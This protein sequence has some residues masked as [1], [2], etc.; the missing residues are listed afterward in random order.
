MP[1]NI[2]AQRSKR[3]RRFLRFR[4]LSL[5]GFLTVVA[6]G[7]GLWRSWESTY[8][9]RELEQ[10][11]RASELFSEIEES[12]LVNLVW[13]EQADKLLQRLLPGDKDSAFARCVFAEELF[14]KTNYIDSQGEPRQVFVF[15]NPWHFSMVSTIVATDDQFRL[16]GWKEIRPGHPESVN[17]TTRAG[18]P[19]LTIVADR[20]GTLRADQP[21]RGTYVF[22]LFEDEILPKPVVWDASSR[23]R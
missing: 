13:Q 23:V 18:V 12:L 4:L 6:I 5:F 15:C 16:V 7:L 11:I 3:L 8:E 21:R 22:Q 9:R 14:W 10:S 1:P 2:N 20:P 17:L 19:E